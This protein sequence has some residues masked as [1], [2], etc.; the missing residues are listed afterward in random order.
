MRATASVGC[1][2]AAAGRQPD[3]SAW[4]GAGI[5]PLGVRIGRLT[6]VLCFTLRF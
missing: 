5:M 1:V 3:T 6:G 4:G 2:Q